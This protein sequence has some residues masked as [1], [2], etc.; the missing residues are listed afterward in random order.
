MRKTFPLQ[1]W[2]TAELIL[3]IPLSH[4]TRNLHSDNFT[5]SHNVNAADVLCTR[6]RLQGPGHPFSTASLTKPS[7]FI[8]STQCAKHLRQTGK[9]RRLNQKPVDTRSSGAP[10]RCTTRS[11]CPARRQPMHQKKPAHTVKFVNI[12]TNASFLY[13]RSTP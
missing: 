1:V 5:A 9:D 7:D 2:Q 10:N 8:R 4:A 11:E 6:H 12:Y 13:V 3:G